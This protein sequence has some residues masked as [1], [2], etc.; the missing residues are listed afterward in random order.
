LRANLLAFMAKRILIV[1]DHA[2]TRTV[3]RTI[4]ESDR[5]ESFEIVEAVNGLDCLQQYEAKGPFDLILL[6]VNM[7]ELDGYETCRLL[8]EQGSRVPIVFVT[9]NK[10]MKDY[11]A[12][13]GAGGDSFIVKPV[14]R[15]ALRSVVG[16]FT[17]V[18]RRSA[19]GENPPE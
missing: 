9:G 10:D 19:A 5:T 2:P 16:L 3:V 13:R 1:D 6:D 8:R 4:L 15:A 17:S 18:D 12:G 11:Q 7:P 14:A